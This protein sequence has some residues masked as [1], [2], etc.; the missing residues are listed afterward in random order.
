MESTLNLDSL[1]RK[2][3]RAAIASLVGFVLVLSSL[4]YSSY[5]LSSL[6]KQISQLSSELQR[7]NREVDDKNKQLKEVNKQLEEAADVL[8]LSPHE[9][10]FLKNHA[11]LQSSPEG[12]LKELVEEKHNV[13]QEIGEYKALP[14][15]KRRRS[16]ITVK[17]YSRE[18]DGNRVR[19]ALHRLKQDHGFNTW[20]DEGRETVDHTN[21]IWVNRPDVKPEDVKLA[22]YYLM[23]FGFQ[24]KYIGPP[25][26][27]P[28]SA[29]RV[30]ADVL[31]VAEPKAKD[32]PS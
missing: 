13:E 4:L 26:S 20:E 9:V 18:I 24:I 30:A 10:V 19:N 6:Q 5:K 21:A 2:S 22:A 27:T 17:F 3:N 32:E 29:R 16:A 15:Q 31:V 28:E 1:K 25:S 14:S 11:L 12:N 7:L 23:L 8:G